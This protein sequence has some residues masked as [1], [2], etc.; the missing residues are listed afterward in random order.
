[1]EKAAAEI[2]GSDD[3]AIDRAPKLSVRPLEGEYAE[4]AAEKFVAIQASKAQQ[5]FWKAFHETEQIALSEGI[6]DSKIDSDVNGDEY[7]FK[8]ILKPQPLK[9]LNRTDGELSS[10]K[11]SVRKMQEAFVRTCQVYEIGSPAVVAAR[12]KLRM[13]YI[14]A[15]KAAEE[16]ELVRHP[17][18]H[19]NKLRH[20]VVPNNM[21]IHPAAVT[22][23]AAKMRQRGREYGARFG[24]DG[25]L[26]GKISE[27][28]RRATKDADSKF[29][30]E[31]DFAGSAKAAERAM[32]VSGAS[33]PDM[34]W[35]FDHSLKKLRSTPSVINRSIQVR[36]SLQR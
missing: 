21:V 33:N 18:I 15:G 7:L 34:R 23:A 36:I 20:H 30:L 16:L 13:F 5:R 9:P 19:L 28:L 32:S 35:V 1:M 6:D 4:A 25:I 24:S 22:R 27:T 2:Q 10:L 14:E 31:M 11:F 12:H 3:S 17:A 29:D 8:D 26:T